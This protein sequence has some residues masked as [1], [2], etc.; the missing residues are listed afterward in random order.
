M[1]EELR[2]SSVARE[3]TDETDVVNVDPPAANPLYPRTLKARA[4]LAGFFSLSWAEIL[5]F[6]AFF[7]YCAAFIYES[8]FVINGVRYFCLFDDDMISMR[9]AA[10]FAHHHGLVWNPGGERVLGFTNPLW[11]L[12]MSVF[13]E[14]PI[15]ESKMALCIQASGAILLAVSI[16]FVRAIVRRIFPD[17]RYAAG[18]AMV[19]V[20][21]YGSLLNWSLQGTEVS[22]LTLFVTSGVWFALK[23]IDGEGSARALYLLLGVS[24]VCRVDM[25]VFAGS[26]LLALALVQPSRWKRHLIWG[27]CVVAVFLAA[28][29]SFNFYYYGNILPNTYYL[30]VTGYPLLGRLHRGA[31]VALIFALPLLPIV[32]VVCLWLASAFSRNATLL[33]VPLLGQIAYSIWVGG[34][35]W[36]WWG[37]ANRYVAI[38][39]PLFFVLSGSALAEYSNRIGHRFA[40]H[41]SRVRF[42]RSCALGSFAFATLFLADC[43]HLRAHLLLS[44][45]MQTSGPQPCEC[46]EDMVRQALLLKSLTAPDAHIG[47]VWAGTIPYFSD[48]YA[49][50]LL[51]KS[52]AKIAHE[53]MRVNSPFARRF[54]FWPGHLKWDYEYS[55]GE[56]KPDVITQVWAVD[57]ETIVPLKEDYVPVKVEGFQWYVRRESRH[58]R[59]SLSELMSLA[60]AAYRE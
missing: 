14:L 12:F 10:N 57:P 13:H 30:K 31:S 23:V 40:T 35:A 33:I 17:Y 25:A 53:P 43:E 15:P 51:G 58:L 27:G 9:F 44:R 45:P 54:G 3:V 22:L 21:F 18:L 11:V 29:G 7:V 24:T 8:S 49:I 2:P 38:V 20:A 50:D 56:L 26:L 36:E 59:P 52:D 46:N 1:R 34:D 6:V 37:G 42:I 32:A 47:V 55:I 28:Q 5:L 19:L 41:K 60:V 16:F 48:R 39:M 4:K